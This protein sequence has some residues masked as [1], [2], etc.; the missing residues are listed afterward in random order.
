MSLSNK[1]ALANVLDSRTN[2]S[3]RGSSLNRAFTWANT[4]QGHSHW[5][6]VCSDLRSGIELSPEDRAILQ[7]MYDQNTTR[8][9]LNPAKET[10]PMSIL[11]LHTASNTYGKYLAVDGQDR[12]VLE[13]KSGEIKAFK[14]DEIE[15]V[16][17][18]TVELATAG[19]SALVYRSKEGAVKVGDLLI[20]GDKGM[21]FARVK[22]V[23]TKSKGEH[24]VLAGQLITGTPIESP[25]A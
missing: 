17:P 12:I 5:S 9:I 15:E 14:R 23:N 1:E 2:G 18:Y 21:T 25:E 3:A 11:Y 7:A 19:G 22:A 8:P 16:A 20:I 6:A 4:A 10:Q 24:P 13:M